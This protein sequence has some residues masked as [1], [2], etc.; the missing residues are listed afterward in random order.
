MN[1]EELSKKLLETFKEFQK[2]VKKPHILIAGPTGVGKSSLINKIF[3]EKV[4]EE[5]KGEPITDSVK[6]Y[7]REDLG[8]ILYDSPGCEIGNTERFKKEVINAIQQENIHLI[9]YCIASTGD[10]IETQDKDTIK[11]F[12]EKNFPVSAVF[13]HCE[14]ASEEKIKEFKEEI[15]NNFKGVDIYITSSKVEHKIFKEEFERL[16]KDA[17]EKLPETLK[18]AFISTQKVS[19]KE[20]WDRAHGIIV[21]HIAGAFTISFVPIPF[22]DAPILVGNQMT[23]IARI[24]YIYDL[25]GL[26]ATI[27]GGAGGGLIGLLMTDLGKFLS[28]SAI[29]K[30]L[31]LIPGVKILANLINGGVATI[32]TAGIGEAINLSCYKLYEEMLKGNNNVDFVKMFGDMVQKYATENVKSEKKAEDYKIPD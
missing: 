1:A 2:N 28:K 17:I 24:L 6:K 31:K 10:R 16:I 13:T 23:M 3:G 14:S 20:K 12:I 7:E 18:D 27:T 30:I 32:L 26:E 22:A 15:N 11:M 4:A 5:G 19:L 21:Q 25:D 9:W 29:T 8:V